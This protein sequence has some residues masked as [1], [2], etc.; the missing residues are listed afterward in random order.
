VLLWRHQTLEYVAGAGLLLQFGLP[1]TGL[2]AIIALQP[3][4]TA[5]SLDAG[6]M[7]SDFRRGLLRDPG[8]LRLRHNPASAPGLS[9]HRRRTWIAVVKQEVGN[10]SFACRKNI[11]QG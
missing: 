3:F 1:P 6:T 11:G 2:A 4:L 9:T 10:G 7:A 5:A 8:V